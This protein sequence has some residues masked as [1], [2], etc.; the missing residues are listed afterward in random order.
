MNQ[1]MSLT[2]WAIAAI[3]AGLP[4]VAIACGDRLGTGH[5]DAGGAEVSEPTI[6][7]GALGAVQPGSGPYP[8]TSATTAYYTTPPLEPPA[9][10]CRELY[11]RTLYH[12]PGSLVSIVAPTSPN[13]ASCAMIQC[14]CGEDN[15]WQPASSSACS[16]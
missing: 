10:G 2:K 13:G 8:C 3:V 16:W 6:P 15:R 12:S 4:I 7:V 1:P 5:A 11:E 14:L 9:I